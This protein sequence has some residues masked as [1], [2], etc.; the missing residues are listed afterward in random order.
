MI[1]EWE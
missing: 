1:R